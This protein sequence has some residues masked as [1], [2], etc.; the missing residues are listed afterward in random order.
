MGSL[1]HDGVD[2]TIPDSQDLLDTVPVMRT[3]AEEDGVA[4]R[5]VRLRPPVTESDW[6]NLF[7]NYKAGVVSESEVGWVLGEQVRLEL[8]R[9]WRVYMDG[10]AAYHEARR[11]RE[12]Y[13][14]T[15]AEGAG[16]DT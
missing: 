15:D 6:E 10:E 8:A 16:S 11:V 14:E 5:D 4:E 1:P 2:G 13:P 3:G 12:L 9:R 7:L